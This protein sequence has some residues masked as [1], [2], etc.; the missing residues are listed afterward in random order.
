[1]LKLNKKIVNDTIY[2]DMVSK[3]MYKQ[4]T[5]DNNLKDDE[6]VEFASYCGEQTSLFKVNQKTWDKIFESTK[7]MFEFCNDKNDIINL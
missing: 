4:Y 6:V 5:I 3:I 2:C 7:T 1:M